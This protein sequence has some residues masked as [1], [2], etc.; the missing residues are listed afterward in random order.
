MSRLLE[1]ESGTDTEGDSG[2]NLSNS[3]SSTAATQLGRESP[4]N[5]NPALSLRNRLEQFSRRLSQLDLE[6]KPDQSGYN[7]KVVIPPEGSSSRRKSPDSIMHDDDKEPSTDK[8]KIKFQPIGS[9]PPMRPSVCKISGTQPFSMV[10]IFLQ[11]RLKVDNIYC[12]VN[13]SFA[14]SPQQIVGE[15]WRQFKVK[16]E[17]I[18]SYCGSVAFG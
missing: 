1:S 11:R 12:Y 15:L 6:D 8:V 3:L 4:R 7:E 10:L 13:N 9:I 16:D 14:P 2:S 5:K 17:L 18:I